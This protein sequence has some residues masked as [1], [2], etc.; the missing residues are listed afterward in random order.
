MKKIHN[1][2]NALGSLVDC[3]FQID[4]AVQRC[5]N[6][7]E[8][9][10]FQTENRLKG[11]L[12]DWNTPLFETSSAIQKYLNL[13]ENVLSQTDNRLQDILR[14]WNT[15]LFET[16]GVMQ[17]YLN[18]SENVLVETGNKWTSVF[19]LFNDVAERISETDFEKVITKE[20]DVENGDNNININD[21]IVN[22]EGCLSENVSLY[23]KINKIIN[24]SDM[25]N[26]IV[27]LIIWIF[28]VVPLLNNISS[29]TKKLSLMKTNT[30]AKVIVNDSVSQVNVNIS[31]LKVYAEKGKKS[32][33]GFK[34][35]N[36]ELVALAMF[37]A[38]EPLKKI[39][40]DFAKKKI[41][42]SFE[43]C[44]SVFKIRGR[45]KAR[46]V[47]EKKCMK[48]IKEQLNNKVL[49]DIFLSKYRYVNCCEISVKSDC[50]LNSSTICNI[51]FGQTV[52]IVYKNNHWSLIQFN[53][54][55]EVTKGWI[56]TYHL[57]RFD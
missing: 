15:P 41:E 16:S 3:S 32:Y 11:I 18:L 40:L 27:C 49:E 34:R 19:N 38:C 10:L 25:K 44:L 56:T 46:K 57:N 23:T 35:E 30:I 13:S 20:D 4:S 42:E 39:Y 36:P 22:I 12:G 45:K 31:R 33:I 37:L 26:P 17:K 48:E 54:N 7:S 5:L 1:Q 21:T 55:G 43:W 6:L 2:Y 52:E 51:Y 47:V 9:V 8:N 14:D 28:I 53:L 29:L 24:S 50:R